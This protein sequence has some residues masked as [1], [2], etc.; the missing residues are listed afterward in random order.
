MGK[1][2]LI[3]TLDINKSI[4]YQIDNK[5][6]PKYIF[7]EYLKWKKKML[8]IIN[9]HRKDINQNLI[10]IILN[11]I[12]FLRSNEHKFIKYNNIKIKE[13]FNFSND[14]YEQNN[15]FNKN[16]EEYREMS[17]FLENFLKR[18]KNLEEIKDIITVK[19]KEAV[20]KIISRIKINGI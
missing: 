18:I 6:T 16:N 15:I 11:H 3:K 12:Y 1:L 9:M 2:F 20:N 14:P 10:P 7:G 13:F 4:I 8:N 5:S 19:E 17:L